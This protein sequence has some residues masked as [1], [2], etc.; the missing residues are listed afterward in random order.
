MNF[1]NPP[2]NK[3]VM[4]ILSYWLENVVF[5]STIIQRTLF[6]YTE[7]VFHVLPQH[8]NKTCSLEKI[9]DGFLYGWIIKN[10]NK[11]KNIPYL[12]TQDFFAMLA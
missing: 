2:T 10:I 8:S 4:S 11:I 9:F 3:K 7:I 5:G 12:P 6:L 1:S